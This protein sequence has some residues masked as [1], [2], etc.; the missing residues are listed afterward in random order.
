MSISDL[1]LISV[2]VVFVF[3]SV[4]VGFAAGV[5]YARNQRKD[6]CSSSCHGRRETREYPHSTTLR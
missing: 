2:G 4:G 5:I 3:F 6:A 1:A